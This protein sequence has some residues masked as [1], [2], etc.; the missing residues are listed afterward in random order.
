VRT[1]YIVGDAEQ[2]FPLAIRC[3][4]TRLPAK[5]GMVVAALAQRLH[6]GAKPG[7]FGYVFLG[8]HGIPTRIQPD[9]NR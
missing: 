8:F 9:E 3:E 7:R 6:A 2:V 4:R 5:V 1:Q